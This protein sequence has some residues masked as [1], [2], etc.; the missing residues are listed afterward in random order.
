[1]DFTLRKYKELL[2][3]LQ[4]KGYKFIT[5]EQYCAQKRALSLMERVHARIGVK[6]LI[7]EQFTST[8]YLKS[9]MDTFMTVVFFN[10]IGV[11]I[12]ALTLGIA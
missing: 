7:S 12:V 1:M 2:V 3:C 8:G 10:Y 5:F 6:R 9:D 11:L 4:R